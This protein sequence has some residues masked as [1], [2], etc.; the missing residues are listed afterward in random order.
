[1]P[2]NLSAYL[3]FAAETAFLA[4]RQTLA[5]YQSGLSPE[6]KPDRSPVTLADRAAERFIRQRIEEKH[7]G[8]AILGEE[9]GLQGEGASH[10]WLI[11]PIDGTKSFMRGVPLF[12]VLIGLEIEG[13]VRVGAAYFPALDEII[14]AASG[15]GC[16]WNGRRARVSQ[17]S[18]LDQSLVLFSDI[19]NFD[20][21]GRVQE[22]ERIR[23]AT[24]QQAGW[25]DA[26]GY[27]LVATGRAELMLDPAANIWDCGPFPPILEEAGGYIGDWQG[28]RTIKANEAIATSLTLLP[29]VLRLIEG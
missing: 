20:K 16:F 13:V 11:D 14:T 21:Y 12:A 18:S 19:A 26:Y 10:L 17:S 24:Y 29:Q 9:F 4:G 1:M 23:K 5:Y 7:P 25:G 3:D 8:H 6:Y 2:E 22:W 27:L 28:N 15:T